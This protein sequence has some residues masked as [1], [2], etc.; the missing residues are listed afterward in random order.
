[1]DRISKVFRK[2]PTFPLQPIDLRKINIE[3]LSNYIPKSMLLELENDRFCKEDRQVN[4]RYVP[5]SRAVIYQLMQDINK[6]MEKGSEKEYKFI[7]DNGSE[8]LV[9]IFESFFLRKR[10]TTVEFL[11]G[12]VRIYGKREN[13]F[14]DLITIKAHAFNETLAYASLLDKVFNTNFQQQ[15]LQEAQDIYIDKKHKLTPVYDNLMLSLKKML[16]E[17]N[18]TK[19]EFEATENVKR[20]KFYE[21]HG[22]KEQLKLEEARE[23]GIEVEPK[24]NKLNMQQKNHTEDETEQDIQ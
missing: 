6:M 20:K 22:I 13:D 23:E 24:R 16:K 12:N 8:F 18:R 3:W 1:M 15:L 10:S 2:E 4:D 17:Y 9:K 5:D 11:S 19:L 21:I 14:E 7:K